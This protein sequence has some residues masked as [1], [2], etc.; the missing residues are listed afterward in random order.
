M[1]DYNIPMPLTLLKIHP[2]VSLST[3]LASNPMASLCAVL[4]PRIVSKS[5]RGRLRR[6][7]CCRSAAGRFAESWRIST[8]AGLGSLSSF[9]V[10]KSAL[11][12]GCLFR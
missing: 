8:I 6:Q 3:P 10:A 2:R 7:R 11:F 12:C 4:S 1:N 5:S 9:A